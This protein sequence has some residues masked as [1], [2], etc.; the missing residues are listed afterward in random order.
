MT[1]ETR[2]AQDGLLNEQ[3][4]K[5]A[6]AITV[7]LLAIGAGILMTLPS[8]HLLELQVYQ[9]AIVIVG[10]ALGFFFHELFKRPERRNSH[11]IVV[12]GLVIWFVAP[13]T[14]ALY[15]GGSYATG[16]W[17][18]LFGLFALIFAQQTYRAQP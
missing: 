3:E 12:A 6:I 8:S 9:V 1:T 10:V 11:Y 16:T 14:I 2:A 4:F 15:F 5:G 18:G 17:L 7:G 13:G